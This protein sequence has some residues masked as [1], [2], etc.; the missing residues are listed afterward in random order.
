MTF[1]EYEAIVT[2]VPASLRNNLDRINL[3]VRGLQEEAGKVGAM[4]QSATTSGRLDLTAEQQAD[5]R[6]RLADALWYV[7]LLAKESGTPLGQVASLSASQVQERF[8]R[9]DPEQR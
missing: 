1:E 4:L 6:D 3:P 2:Q 7:A 8:S 5:L 9:L